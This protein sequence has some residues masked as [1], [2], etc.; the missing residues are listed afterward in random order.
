[1][2]LAAT[3]NDAVFP[4]TIVWLAGCVVIDGATTGIV[5]ISV[6]GLLLAVPALLL[7][8]TENAALLSAV[9]SAGV[10]YVEEVAPLSIAPFLLHWYVIGEVPV[11]ATLNVAVLPATML[12]LAG[13]VEIAGATTVGGGGV[14]GGGVTAL[15]MPVRATE[16]SVPLACSNT[17]L[18]EYDCEEVGLNLTVPIKLFP[19]AS[20]IGSA[21]PENENCEMEVVAREMVMLWRFSFVKT[22]VCDMMLVARMNVLDDT[23]P[24]VMAVGLTRTFACAPLA[25]VK[26]IAA[27]AARDLTLI[28]FLIV[29]FIFFPSFSKAPATCAFFRREQFA[30][31]EADVSEST[32][33]LLG[34]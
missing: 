17:S 12:M 2:P 27:A 14:G 9:V 1:M 23:A 15:P 5:T 32:S 10:V 31:R 18:P 26:R 25:N 13:C 29:I 11:A 7:T 3:V 20:V 6:A 21:G 28:L 24:N 34:D 19:G 30:L 8:A 22:T 33:G 16:N 4:A